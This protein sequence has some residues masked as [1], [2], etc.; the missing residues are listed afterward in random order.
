MSQT[1]VRRIFVQ[2]D[3]DEIG[4][5]H[6]SAAEFSQHYPKHHEWLKMAIAEIVTGKRFAFG[7]YKTTFDI[8]GDPTISL[9]GSIILKKETY[10]NVVQLKNLYVKP[11]V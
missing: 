4:R 10:T 9:A 5:L 11:E 8:D 7:L 1:Q 2:R 3:A 6:G